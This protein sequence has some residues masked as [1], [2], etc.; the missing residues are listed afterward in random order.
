MN[1]E[2]F[3]RFTNHRPVTAK[4]SSHPSTGGEVY[5]KLHANSANP[6]K[7]YL[8]F[9]NSSSGQGP[10]VVDADFTATFD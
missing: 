2:E 8:V 3:A 6:Q 7:Y 4:F 9:R 1:G 10:S 5:W